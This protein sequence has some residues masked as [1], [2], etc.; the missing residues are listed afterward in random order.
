MKK[1]KSI[2]TF[3]HAED[4]PEEGTLLQYEERNEK[5]QLILEEKYY[6]DASLE[7]RIE[8]SFDSE[9]RL[10]W[11][12]EFSGENQ[13]PDQHTQYTYSAAGRLEVAEIKYQD[14][15]STFRKYEHDESANSETINIVDEEGTYEGKE[16][17]RFDSEGK[18]LQEVIHDEEEKLEQDV[19][20]E[21][22]DNGHLTERV[23]MLPDDYETVEFFD[24]ERNDQGLIL[25]R[26]VEDED[27]KLLRLDKFE[28]DEKGNTTQH[29]VQDYNQG[30]ALVDQWEYD[31]KERIIKTR[32]SQPNGDVL[33]ESEY[34]YNDNDLLIE[35]ENR[36]KQG[37]SLS[38]Y[39]YEYFE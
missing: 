17:R 13:E 1:I 6:A 3:V 11:E 26:K 36:T 39:K 30:W 24:Y 31:E 29:E 20:R 32:R 5:E 35:Q 34:R 38:A 18:I 25:N 15:S 33:Q 27:G 12:K 10:E 4:S 14:G 37:M 16:Y 19:N 28:Y 8:R 22:D 2:S 7:S 21:Y 9:G 23:T